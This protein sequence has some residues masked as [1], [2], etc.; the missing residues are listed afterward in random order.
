ML[1]KYK[2]KGIFLLIAIL[3]CFFAVSFVKETYRNYKIAKEIKN[4]K[5][6]IELL[7]SA[8]IE[9]AN[10]INYLKTDNFVEKEARLKFG[11]QKPGEKAFIIEKN[12]GQTAGIIG[13]EKAEKEISNF[14][15]WEEYF[16]GS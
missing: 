2:L 10:L 3:A 11:L 1:E 6:D 5:E 7:Q 13:N 8:N 16:F 12:S 15:K 4:L 14:Q 9:L